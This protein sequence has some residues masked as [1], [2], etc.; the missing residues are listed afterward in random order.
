MER[1]IGLDAHATSCTFAVLSERGRRLDSAV[2]ETNGRALVKS[3]RSVPGDKHLRLEEGTQ[4]AWL[5]EV[6]QGHVRELVVTHA[7]ERKRGPK[8]D[9]RDA[10][11]LAESLRIGAVSPVYKDRGQLSELRAHADVYAKLVTYVVRAQNRLKALFRSRGVQVVGGAVYTQ[12]DRQAYLDELARPYR[13]S[14]ELL[15]SEIDAL[16]AIKKEAEKQLIAQSHQH[17]I[18]AVLQTCPG[19]GPIRVAETIPIIVSP[20]RFRTA[21]QLW[22]Y[23]GLA[24]VMRSSSDWVQTPQGWQRAETIR[25]RGL[26]RNYNRRL[27]NIFKG[28]ATTVITQ[29]LEPMV[30]DYQR[31]LEQGTKPPMAKL[32]LA[33]RISAT[34]LAMWKNKEAYHPERYRPTP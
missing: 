7:Y 1:Y 19:M 12:R 30:G 20:Y 6:L 21:R 5:Y 25:T 14:A 26:N 18:S 33:R 4:S 16:R 27:K 9:Q 31:C 13:G 34:V 24:I 23:S 22:A 15:Y 17:C 29:R 32:T 10:F 2:V 8:D 11:H 3:L 28:A